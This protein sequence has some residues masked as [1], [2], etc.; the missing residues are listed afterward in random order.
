MFKKEP[1]NRENAHRPLRGEDDLERLF[2][3]RAVRK[4]SKSLSFQYE[5]TIYQLRPVLPNRFRCTHVNV[6]KRAGKQ[7]L[8]ESQGEAHPYVRW[9]EVPYEQP[10]ILDSK[11]LE[12]Y[13]PDRRKK[14]PRKDH[15]WRRSA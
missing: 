5:G 9:E 1:N 12:A 10:K 4:L 7:L 2:A 13:W 11:E 14:R 6:F 3:H 15:V 8:V